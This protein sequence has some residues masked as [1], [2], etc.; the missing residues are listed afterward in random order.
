M[1]RKIKVIIKNNNNTINISE[2][3]IRVSKGYALNYLIPNSIAEIATPN[4]I[5]H[6]KMLE[7]INAS[8]AKQ[9]KSKII[10]LQRNLN[11]IT[12]I[13]ITKKIG[14]NNYIF[15]RINEKEI[16]SLIYK[17]SGITLNKKQFSIPI[18]KQIGKFT[19]NINL[20]NDISCKLYL[21]ILPINI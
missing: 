4:K 21:H 9:E 6:I 10:K 15:G 8:K 5:K 13:R 16:I 18:I 20:A 2:T 14:D 19:I 17:Y 3:I 1:K 11:D 7:K 12:N